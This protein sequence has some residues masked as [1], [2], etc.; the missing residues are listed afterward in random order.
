MQLMVSTDIALR[1]LIYL[2]QKNATATIQEVATACNIS[3]THLMKVVM[4][5]V[6]ANLLVSERGRNGGVRLAL[7]PRD[8]S[9]GTVV[10]LMENNLALVVCM[11]GDAPTDSCPLLPRCR[12]KGVFSQAQDA[13]L[14][15]LD[16]SSLADLLA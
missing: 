3:K 13:F 6:G 11:K 14:A 9:I 7:E 8:L 4:T 10:R 12:L 5:L 1:T 2:G 16:Q 15:S